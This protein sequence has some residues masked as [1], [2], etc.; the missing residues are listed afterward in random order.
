MLLERGETKGTNEL[1]FDGVVQQDLTVQKISHV[2]KIFYRKGSA[3]PSSARCCVTSGNKDIFSIEDKSDGKM[4]MEERMVELALSK[5]GCS[6][7]SAKKPSTWC[8]FE[9]IKGAT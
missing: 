9:I 7:S 2:A 1:C 8:L 3:N 6:N 4:F 5:P